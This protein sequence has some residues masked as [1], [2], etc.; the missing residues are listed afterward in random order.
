MVGKFYLT[1]YCYTQKLSFIS[2]VYYFISNSDCRGIKFFIRENH[3]IVFFWTFKESLFALSHSP[4]FTSSL[5]A[6]SESWVMLS[7]EI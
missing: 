2:I 6:V 1:V 7:S 3:K 4:T 5:L